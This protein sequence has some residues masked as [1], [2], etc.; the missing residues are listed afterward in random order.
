MATR[1]TTVLYGDE[2]ETDIAPGNRVDLESSS[3]ESVPAPPPMRPKYPTPMPSPWVRREA[4]RATPAPRGL[5]TA[6][7]VAAASILAAALAYIAAARRVL[8]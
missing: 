4:V 8:A 1:M 2:P 3:G 7:G 6:L 5:R